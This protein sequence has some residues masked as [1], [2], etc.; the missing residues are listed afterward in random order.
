[1]VRSRSQPQFRSENTLATTEADQILLALQQL[2]SN[3]KFATFNNNNINR[4]FKLPKSL[5]TTMP[6]F[7]GKSK[8][9]TVWWYVLNKSKSTIRSQKKTKYTTYQ[10]FLHGDAVQTFKNINSPNRENLGEI[11]TMFPRKDVKPQARVTAKYK[12]QQLVF[13][14]TNQELNDFWTNCRK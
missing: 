6:T 4:I 13:S 11:L 3:S 8:N 9:W 14:P 10:S 2:V 7:D 1:M 12:F 5:N